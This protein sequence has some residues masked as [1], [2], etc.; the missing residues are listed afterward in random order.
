M[1]YLDTNRYNQILGSFRSPRVSSISSSDNVN[2]FNHAPYSFSPLKT[3]KQVRNL[4]ILAPN[5]TDPL[6]EQSN[7]ILIYR[8]ACYLANILCR[9]DDFEGVNL[10]GNVQTY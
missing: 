3:D 5:F 2:S 4:S 10:R 7:I 8:A 1:N 6:V 9:N